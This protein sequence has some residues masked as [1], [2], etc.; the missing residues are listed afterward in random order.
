MTNVIW[1]KF[2][3]RA[4]IQIITSSNWK[5]GIPK[6]PK[7]PKHLVKVIDHHLHD[8][9]CP[10]DHELLTFIPHVFDQVT[11]EAIA[12]AFKLKEKHNRANLVNPEIRKKEEIYRKIISKTKQQTY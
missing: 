7:I 3:G 1:E 12:E 6:D 8:E 5:K 10:T 11:K 4:T 2:T 9:Y